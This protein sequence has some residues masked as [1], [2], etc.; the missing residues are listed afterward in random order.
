MVKGIEKF[1]EHFR[2]YKD[3]YVIIGGT[4]CE[5]HEDA[6]GQK[7]RVTKDIDMILIIEACL[8]S[9]WPSSGNL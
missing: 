9:L 8:M 5:F 7:P 1:R 4:A 6:A 3:N 2:E